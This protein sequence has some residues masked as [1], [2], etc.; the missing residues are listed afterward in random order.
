MASTFG[1]LEIARSGMM[2]YNAAIQTTA[3]NM[4]NIET[5]GYSRQKTNITAMVSPSSSFVVQGSGVNVTSITRERDEYY[6]IK[7]QNTQSTYNYY[8][9]EA[10]YLNNLQ[11]QLCG[12]VVSKDKILLLDAFDSFYASLSSLKDAP[13][14]NTKRTE[15][16][17]FAQ[18]FAEKL[19]NTATSLQQLQEEANEQIKTT[20]EQINGIA[21]KIVSL[22][23]QINLIE[24]YGSIANDLRDQRSVLLDELAGYC[25]VEYKEVEPADGIGGNQ[26]YVYIN[27]GTLVDNYR[28]NHLVINQKLTYTN[29]NDIRG[30]YTI[31]WK[32]GTNFNAYSSDLGGQLQALFEFRDG[33]NSTTLEGKLQDVSN[34]QDGKLVLTLS[35][36]NCS[37]VRDL[38]IPAEDGELVIK[39]ITY[40]YDSFEAVVDQDGNYTYVFTMKS[41]MVAEDS[42]AL[43]A[44]LKYGYKVSAGQE[45]SSKGIPYY[46]AQLNEFVRTFAQEFNRV[47]NE[48]YDTN[49]NLGIDFFNARVAATGD[50]YDMKES[51]KGVDPSFSSVAKQN[52]DGT[53]TGSYYYMTAL[54]FCV[55]DA[56]KED[57][58]LFACK[59]KEAP[60]LHVGNDN[61]D[62]LQRLL[63]LKS[64]SK[65]FLHGNPDS[66][67][68]SITATLGINAEMANS[69]EESQNNLLYA[70]ESSRMSISGVDEDEVGTD[71]ITY[72]AML[73]YQYKVIAVMNEVLDRLINDTV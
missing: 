46:M 4:A 63:D 22:N 31:S 32:D 36:T 1:S 20:V 33:N 21:D 61:G 5:K 28:S 14:D 11:D 19:T 24:A 6:D 17:T 12:N 72:R 70:I 39:N 48:G 68:Q 55:T 60:D 44:A 52:G 41:N 49:D 23:E 56:F 9:T 59:E 8:M 66:F 37:D 67:I 15:T 54:N 13:G 62:N 58:T 57:P 29:I 2:T 45:I 71:L 40:A 73:T 25:N 42:V 47:H 18:T 43:Q 69:M 10:H 26:F 65:M 51:V 50:N 53:Y 64:D 16:I 34:N 38:N 27:G 30:C 7:Y 35:N 3:H